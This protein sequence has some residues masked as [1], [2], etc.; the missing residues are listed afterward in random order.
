MSI[1]SMYNACVPVLDRLLSNLEYVLKKGEANAAERGIDPE[2]FLNARLAPDMA[3]LTKQVQIAAS[4]SKVCPHRLVGSTPPVYEDT[5]STFEELYALI[6]KA[7][8]EVNSFTPEML[9]GTEGRTFSV[10]L[11]PTEREFVGIAYHSGFILPNV[12]FHC[13][14]AYNILRHNGVPLGKMDFFGGG[15]L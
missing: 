12:T 7:R 10:K 8:A 4:M 6:A 11:G 15:N 14:T 5:E 3:T 1:L 13:T 9:N 2:V